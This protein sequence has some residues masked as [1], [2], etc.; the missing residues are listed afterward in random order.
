MAAAESLKRVAEA[1]AKAEEERLVAEAEAAMVEAERATAQ[2]AAAKAAA[3]A[4]AR[5]DAS[6][7]AEQPVSRDEFLRAMVVMTSTISA[8]I[9]NQR[10]GSPE[11]LNVWNG[12]RTP[13]KQ[14]RSQPPVHAPLGRHQMSAQFNHATQP[15]PHDAF[16]P[17]RSAAAQSP[18]VVHGTPSERLNARVAGPRSPLLPYGL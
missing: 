11:P 18:R 1:A 16:T 2:E 6:D 4:A 7:P 14:E 9:A 17:L 8:E 15:C 13:E 12:G 5:D 3:E 10:A